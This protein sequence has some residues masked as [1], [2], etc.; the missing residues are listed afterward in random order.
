M[1]PL[2]LSRLVAALRPGAIRGRVDRAVTELCYDSRAVRPGAAFFAQPGAHVDG[3]R[4][5]DAAV[6]AGAMAVVHSHDLGGERLRERGPDV[7]WIRVADPTAALSAGAACFFG[8]PC[9]ELTMVGVTGTNGKSTTA[10]MIYDLLRALEVPA[11]L[12]STVGVDYGAGLAANPEHV[13]TPLAVEMHAALRAM[14]DAGLRTAVVEASSWALSGGSKRLAD[15]RFDSG[16]LTSFSHDHLELHGTAAAYL[17]AKLNLFRALRPGGGGAVAPPHL[18]GQVGAVT[19]APV[20][21][22]G[23]AGGGGRA[24]VRWA[25][26]AEVDGDDRGAGDTRGPLRFALHLDGAAVPASLAARGRF[27][28]DNC[29]AAAT[30]VARQYAVPAARLSGPVGALRL[31]PGHLE[32]VDLGQPFRL[33]VDYAHTP[34]AFRATLSLLAGEARAAGGRLIAVFGSAGERDIDKRAMQGRVAD[35]FADLVVL[36]D[37]DCRGEDA[38]AILREIAAGCPRRTDGD[39]LI[40]E[41]DRRT[42]IARAVAAARG[43]DVVALLGKGHEASMIGPDGARPWSERGAAEDALRAAGWG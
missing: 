12:I 19:T 35:R 42:A 13:T 23:T 3:H 21:A 7:T 43:G 17:A 32:A 37:E 4:F 36:T 34:E 16:V 26:R 39:D 11:G 18:V 14:V 28:L 15:L 41:V 27:N 38:V 2:P 33:I 5:I 25:C 30:V 22:F 10:W 29:L 20:Y 24:G 40:L 6:A 1:N 31:P 8:H 9:R